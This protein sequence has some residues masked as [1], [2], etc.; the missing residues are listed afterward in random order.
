[1]LAMKCSKSF[2]LD[3]S[4]TWTKN[5]QMYK[6][7]LEKAEEP[8]AKLPTFVGSWES[9]GIPGNIHFCF[10]DYDKAF[11]YVDHN[12]LWKILQKMGKSEHP[13]CLWETCM[14]VKKQSLELDMEQQTFKLGKEYVKAVYCHPA[15]LTYM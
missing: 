2:K 9:K 13:T 12:K 6:L 15:Y 11:D 3:F 1:M 5:F 8:E 7:G 10:F 4:S 14:Q